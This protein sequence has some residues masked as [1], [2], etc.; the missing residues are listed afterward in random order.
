[1]V[2][3]AVGVV[4]TEEK[5]ADD[6]ARLV[7]TEACDDA[8]GRALVFD[9]EHRALVGLVRAVERL[10][11]DAVET[12][13][14]EPGEPIS[15]LGEVG[16]RWGHEHGILGVGERLDEPASTLGERMPRQ[17]LVADRE[18]VEPH[19]RSGGALGEHPH[20]AVS[21]M[22]AL[23]KRVEVEATVGHE[24]DLPVDDAASRQV[25]SECLHQLGE[26]PGHRALVAAAEFDLVA[27]PED[28]GAESVPFRLDMADVGDLSNGLGEHR[29]DGRHHWEVHPT[30]L[31]RDG[32]LM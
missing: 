14:L 7:P 4:E 18:Q 20:P 16:G 1:V 22:D 9:L 25:P 28:D 8:V 6:P 2:E 30:I 3:A 26:V 5:R 29:S 12:C 32:G 27:V 13:S 10:R 17:V 21:R 11:H 19:E 23:L 31:L 15:R 24:D